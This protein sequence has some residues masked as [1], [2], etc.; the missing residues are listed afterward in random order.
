VA[1]LAA[2]H[3]AGVKQGLTGACANGDAMDMP[4][5]YTELYRDIVRDHGRAPH[6]SGELDGATA[7]AEAHNA[8]CGDRIVVTLLLDD[9]GRIRAV[10]HATDGCLLCNASASLMASHVPGLDHAGLRTLH[11]RLAALVAGA[12]SGLLHGDEFRF[13]DLGAL[14]G[15]AAFP[16]RRRCVMLPWEA[17]ESAMCSA[18]VASGIGV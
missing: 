7:R 2:V 11:K 3:L 6:G 15:V 13:G 10:R 4:R 12:P 16:S 14:A 5:V 1:I 17:L 9:G 8:M 18:V